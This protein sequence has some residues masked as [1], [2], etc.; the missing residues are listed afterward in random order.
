MAENANLTTTRKETPAAK[1]EQDTT[2]SEAKASS[3]KRIMLPLTIISFLLSFPILFCI[4]WL[5]Y[6]R[7]GNCEQLLPLGK[8]QIGIV[9]GLIVLFV[10]SNGVVFLRSRFLMLGYIDRGHGATHC[11]PHNRIGTHRS[12]HNREQSGCC[13][14]PSNCDMNYVNA[15]Y[16]E[17]NYVA[18]NGSDGA[19]EINC[20]LWQNDVTKLCYDCY[21]CRKGFIG[22]LRQK[23]YKLGVFLVVVTILLIASHMLLFAT[24][25]WELY[26]L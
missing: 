7:E 15:T 2:M 5:L 14:P 12:I 24:A 25:M 20:D 1:D 16:W 17:K 22:T 18:Y 26:A 13:V 23:W 21:A 9:I 8:L 19:Y 11:D 10:V 4:V 3:I 6:V